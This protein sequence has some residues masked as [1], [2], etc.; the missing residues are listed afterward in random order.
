[1]EA[2]ATKIHLHDGAM[3]VER[4]QDCTA[5][6]EDAKARH[7]EGRHGSKEM[8]HVASIPFVMIEKYLNES[9]ISMHEFS[10]SPVHKVR[11]LNDPALAHFRIWGGKL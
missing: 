11:L 2:L 7:N 9:G 4:T 3:T 5:I 8:R 1:M 10:A 6:A